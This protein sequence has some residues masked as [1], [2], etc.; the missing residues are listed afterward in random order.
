MQ[1]LF[2][3]ILPIDWKTAVVN[4][5]IKKATNLTVSNYRQIRLTSLVA[6]EFINVHCV[7][8]PSW[9]SFMYSLDD[10]TKKVEAGNSADVVYLDLS[11]TFDRIPNRRLLS[12]LGYC[13]LQGNLL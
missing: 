10:W 3:T 12:K 9:H 5:F 4:C 11:K 2:A 8:P 13:V 7:I 1:Q 6:N